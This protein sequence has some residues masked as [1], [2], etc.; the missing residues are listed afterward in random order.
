MLIVNVQ[1]YGNFDMPYVESTFYHPTAT[2]LKQF[3]LNNSLFSKDRN[4]ENVE[5][6]LKS[7]GFIKV[8]TQSI[9][10]GGDY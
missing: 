6:T 8:K 9:N 10:Y 3:G 1:G 2:S 5:R 7:H 4:A